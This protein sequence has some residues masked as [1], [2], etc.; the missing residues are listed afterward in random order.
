MNTTER[1]YR[2]AYCW[3]EVLGVFGGPI[4]IFQS[5]TGKLRN[6]GAK[7]HQCGAPTPQPNPPHNHFTPENP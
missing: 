7:C 1:L 3:M 2:C 6:H 4:E 5:G